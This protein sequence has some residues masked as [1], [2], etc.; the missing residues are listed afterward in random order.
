MMNENSTTSNKSRQSPLPC[1]KELLQECEALILYVAR[2]G[3]VLKEEG[4][5]DDEAF[6]AYDGLVAAVNQ[7]DDWVNLRKSYARVT[8]RTRA[9][10]GISGRSVFDTLRFG[11]ADPNLNWWQKC[12]C[13]LQKLNPFSSSHGPRRP[14]AIGLFAFLLALGLQAA[15]GWAGRINDPSDPSQELGLCLLVCY[16]LIK[17][18]AP[19]L[20]AGLWG[21]IGSC[22]FLMKKLTDRLSD[23][24]YEQSRQKG[25]LARIFVGAFLGIAAVEIFL[26]ED[27]GEAM[28]VGDVN[29]TP[30]L[31]AL[32]AGVATKT[33]YGLLEALIEGIAERVSPKRK[34]KGK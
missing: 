25:D 22:I 14:I 4:K 32:A 31:I 16:W 24:T 29:L 13:Y 20:L 28:M 27:L 9:A 34:D 19:L 7:K 6:A 30:N 33:V 18:L 12:L 17:D 8:A 10:K 26:D 3:D 1:E 5:A 11:T 15:V 23:M 2:H 21:G